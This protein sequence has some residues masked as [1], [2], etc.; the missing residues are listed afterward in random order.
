MDHERKARLSLEV[1]LLQKTKWKARDI[2]VFYGCASE[3]A[4]RIRKAALEAGGHIDY[5]LHS[6]TVRSVMAL[7]GTTPEEEI[8]KRMLELTKGATPG[9]ENE[10]KERNEEQWQSY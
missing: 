1:T 8:R 7:D 9:T 10:S 5:D 4:N 6:V 2:R 3:K